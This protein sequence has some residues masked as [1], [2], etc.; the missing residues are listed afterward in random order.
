MQVYF[1]KYAE[2]KPILGA[3]KIK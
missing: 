2:T 3:K 1:L